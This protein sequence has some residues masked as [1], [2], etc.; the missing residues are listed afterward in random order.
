MTVCT[1]SSG[2]HWATT[3]T[4]STTVVIHAASLGP[5]GSTGGPADMCPPDLEQGEMRADGRA[6]TDFSWSDRRRTQAG[7]DAAVVHRAAPG[8]QL[9]HGPRLPRSHYSEQGRPLR[10]I[11]DRG[12]SLSVAGPAAVAMVMTRYVALLLVLGACAGP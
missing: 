11:H 6:R 8:Q 10:G 7:L 12:T 4:A 9:I 3:A 5:R 1:A 2:H